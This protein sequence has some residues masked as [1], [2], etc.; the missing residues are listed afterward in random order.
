MNLEKYKIFVDLFKNSNQYKKSKT[1]KKQLFDLFLRNSEC[2]KY[3][4]IDKEYDKCILNI[5]WNIGINNIKLYYSSSILY[6]KDFEYI[7]ENEAECT[8][9][10]YY[11][12][13][14]KKNIIMN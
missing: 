5:E 6:Y 1:F 10:V 14:L 13:K 2:K 7:K 3:E 9:K 12:K 11:K 4:Y 8:K